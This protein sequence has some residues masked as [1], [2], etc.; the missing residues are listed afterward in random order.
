MQALVAFLQTGT[1][2]RFLVF[3]IGLAVVVLNKKLGLDLDASAVIA[4]V[5]L[6]LGYVMQSA[7][8]EASDTH[9]AA[10]VEAAKATAPDAPLPAGAKS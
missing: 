9:A 4:D 1:F 7:A 2:R 6:V 8:K 10:K 5:T 3:G